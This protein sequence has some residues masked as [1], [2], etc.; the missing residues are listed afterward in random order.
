[1]FG[2][3]KD[4][5][6]W[7]PK[8]GEFVILPLLVEVDEITGGEDTQSTTHTDHDPELTKALRDVQFVLYYD[9]RVARLGRVLAANTEVA[10]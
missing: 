10:G 3:R 9:G 6:E 8:G 5:G 4:S 1:M 7:N 2:K